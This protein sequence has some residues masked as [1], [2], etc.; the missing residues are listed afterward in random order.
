MD[1]R[2]IP[3]AKWLI[4]KRGSSG[5]SNDDELMLNRLA[6]LAYFGASALGD[7]NEHAFLRTYFRSREGLI[8]LFAEAGFR[9]ARDHGGLKYHYFL[10]FARSN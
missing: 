8:D 1:S 5:A 7:P 9:L 6:I 3:L 4:Y 10:E 2:H